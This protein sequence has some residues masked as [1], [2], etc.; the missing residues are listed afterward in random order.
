[1]IAKRRG[2]S[3]ATSIAIVALILAI[4]AIALPYVSDSM[5][6]STANTMTQSSQ[7]RE[8]Y[9][10]ADE[11]GFNATAA[12]IPHYVYNPTLMTVNK[13]DKVLIHF[14]DTTDSPHTFTLSAYSINVSLTPG[15]KQDISFTANTPGTF[16]FN[17]NFHPTTMRGQLVV[18]G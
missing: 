2:A 9:V 6:T 5:A 1:M 14:Y 13:G 8:F 7:G 11:L 16:M 4:V 3:T 15:Q 17:C 10:V 12:G 18:L